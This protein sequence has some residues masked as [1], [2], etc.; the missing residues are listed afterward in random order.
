M[1]VIDDNEG[2]R[3][4]L[5]DILEDDGYVVSAAG[6]GREGLE[7]AERTAFDIALVDIRLPDM[8]G[9]VV[10]KRL[11]EHCGGTAC[12]IITGNASIQNAVKALQEGANGYFTKPLVLED[13]LYRLRDIAERQRLRRQLTESEEQ[14]RDLFENANDL[15]QRV[16]TDGHFIYV[17]QAWKKSLGYKEEEITGLTVFDILR[18]DQVEHC[19]EVFEQ[20]MAGESIDRLET[21]FVSKSGRE[22]IVEGCV[23]CRIID[24]VPVSTRGIFRD[25]TDRKRNEELLRQQAKA[26][27]F[28]FMA[29]ALPAFASNVPRGAR[30][31][32]VRTFAERFE[33]NVRPRFREAVEQMHRSP[34][35]KLA[36]KKGTYSPADGYLS[37]LAEL[38]T[39][40]G[41]SASVSARGENGHLDILGCPWKREAQGNPVFCLIC[42]AMVMRSFTW[43][44]LEGNVNQR[45]SI[46]N[47]ATTCLFELSLIENTT[48][49]MN[50]KDKDG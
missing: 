17:N 20:V 9:I 28:T 22:L 16:G 21:V 24:G 23:N 15:I 47:G 36:H 10:M 37:W 29:S 7:L 1:L 2:T 39:S 5:T 40:I 41:A 42:R 48:R 32:M 30:D 43:T 14:Y 11:R 49:D 19:R 4:S 46:A 50:G 38:F 13:V 25:I 44:G 31:T 18:P 27:V 34:Y 45:T 12:V 26:E 3:E 33:R 35:A 6:T 8:D